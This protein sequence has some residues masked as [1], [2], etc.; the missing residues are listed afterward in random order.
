MIHHLSIAAHDPQHVAEVLAEIM[1]GRATRF[2]P[3]P[4]SWYAHQLDEHGTGVEI[5]PTGTEL[6][7]AGP[8]GT[9]FAMAP[10]SVSGF[11]PTHF[12]LS[13]A[14]G[15]DAIQAIADREGWQCHLCERG[16]GG[17]HVMEVW[18]ENATMIEILPPP[19]AAEYLALTRGRSEH[20]AA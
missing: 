8:E 12:A 11:T 1:G 14:A 18:I 2:P 3:N 13:V 16:R 5:Y 19:F 6:V 17:F 10:P 20:M 7:P 15:Q 9:G 4:G